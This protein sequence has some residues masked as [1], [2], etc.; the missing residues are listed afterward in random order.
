MSVLCR[1]RRKGSPQQ[2]RQS[3]C[4]GEDL[5]AVAAGQPRPPSC[6]LSALMHIVSVSLRQSALLFLLSYLLANGGTDFLLLCLS[7]MQ[8]S[9]QG[10][11]KGQQASL[12][13]ML[14]FRCAL[15]SATHLA[16]FPLGGGSFP[17]RGF[18]GLLWSV[19]CTWLYQSLRL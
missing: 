8:S 9:A 18:C 7:S 14:H 19:G 16:Q 6:S 5:G 1:R 3:D 11:G 13:L 2:E 10:S 17:K 15:Q 12:S 4:D